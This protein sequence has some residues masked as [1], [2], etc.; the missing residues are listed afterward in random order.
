MVRGELAEG[1][2]FEVGKGYLGKTHKE[3]SQPV[4]KPADHGVF[5]GWH[6]VGVG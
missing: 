4:R 1:V 6:G 5:K 3:G 2:R